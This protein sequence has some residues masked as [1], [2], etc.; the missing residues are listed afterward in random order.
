MPDYYDPI[1]LQA[2]L[3]VYKL[4]AA[5]W[6]SK[7]TFCCR[8]YAVNS[9]RKDILTVFLYKELNSLLIGSGTKPVF[10]EKLTL[11]PDSTLEYSEAT[12]KFQ[13]IYVILLSIA[14]MIKHY[15]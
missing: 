6:G 15:L 10:S 13:N 7:E 4:K 12:F 11:K 8:K 3:R 1:C 9:N 2:F 5:Y 14:V